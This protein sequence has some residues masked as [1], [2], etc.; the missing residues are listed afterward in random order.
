[1][2]SSN[3]LLRMCDVV[4]V[5]CHVFIIHSSSL[6]TFSLRHLL[7]ANIEFSSKKNACFVL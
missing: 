5:A 2:T 4:V 7:T 3:Q 1:M 6:K